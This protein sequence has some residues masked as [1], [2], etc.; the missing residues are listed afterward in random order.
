MRIVVILS[1]RAG[2]VPGPARVG[3]RS[4]RIERVPSVMTS[5]FW[6]KPRSRK[7]MMPRPG[8]L[9]EARTATTSVSSH[10]VSPGRKT[11]R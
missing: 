3:P 11:P 4:Y 5:P 7:V 6:L 9:R 1:C 10:K 2:R 8:W